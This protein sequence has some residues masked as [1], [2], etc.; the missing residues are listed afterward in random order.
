VVVAVGW[1]VVMAAVV[2]EVVVVVR[3][4]VVVVKVAVG[5]GRLR[6]SVVAVEAQQLVEATVVVA[7]L[8]LYRVIRVWNRACLQRRVQAMGLASRLDMAW[9]T[10]PV[11]QSAAKW[12]ILP[13]EKPAV[14]VLLVVVVLEVA[15]RVAMDLRGG[16]RFSLLMPVETFSHSQAPVLVPTLM[17]VLVLVSV[18]VSVLLLAVLLGHTHCQSRPL[19]STFSVDGAVGTVTVPD[20]ISILCGW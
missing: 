8:L 2:G 16:V 3:A 6:R 4:L 7:L 10:S 18:V 15:V 19:L 17:L 14:A 9:A 12:G 5:V 1:V 11:A 13:R 20:T